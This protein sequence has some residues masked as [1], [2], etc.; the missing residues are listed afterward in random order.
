MGWCGEIVEP[1]VDEV[2]DVLLKAGTSKADT[3]HENRWSFA[4]AKAKR[5]FRNK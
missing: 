2:Q 5:I 1:D 4:Q 3:E